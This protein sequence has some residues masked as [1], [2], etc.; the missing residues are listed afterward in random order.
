MKLAWCLG[1]QRQLHE[2]VKHPIGDP[3]WEEI[4]QGF[5]GV[6]HLTSKTLNISHIL[7]ALE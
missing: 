4:T 5:R 2:K 1:S 3:A 7:E 6:V